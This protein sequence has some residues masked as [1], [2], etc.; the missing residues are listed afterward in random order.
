ML[1][2]VIDSLLA[3]FPYFLM[4]SGTALAML[5]AS[6][7]LYIAVTPFHELRL[8]RAGNA[9]AAVA[10]AGAS[11]G[12]AIPLAFCLAAS[13][14]VVD[15]LVWGSVTLVM[16]LLAYLLA[17]LLLGGFARRIEQGDLAAAI[18][19]LGVQLSV[20]AINAAAISG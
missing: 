8:V 1:S 3:G 19:L 15:I 12:L 17:A 6:V 14:N 11:L 9:A 10:L 16:Q 5:V 7:A 13:V 4:H 20:A 2:G 18:V